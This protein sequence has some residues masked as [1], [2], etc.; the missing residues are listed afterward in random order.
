MLG[1]TNSNGLNK[2]TLQRGGGV[3]MGEDANGFH[4]WNIDPQQIQEEIII[5]PDQSQTYNI[6]T[7]NYTV[8]PDINGGDVVNIGE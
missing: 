7:L 1:N 2:A 3:W 5:N 8:E 4:I 6:T